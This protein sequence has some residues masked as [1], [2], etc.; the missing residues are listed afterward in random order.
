MFR[1]SLLCILSLTLLL[2]GWAAAA[3]ESGQGKAHLVEINGPI[4]PATADYFTRSL[5]KAEAQG[6]AAQGHA[7]RHA[8]RLL[9]V[10]YT[11]LILMDPASDRAGLK[12]GVMPEIL[13]FV[14][15]FCLVENSST[16]GP[17]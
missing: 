5:D 3:A 7:G 17:K 12:R 14:L 9:A 4:G 8:F 2:V 1:R 10:A 6:A 16:S 13:K 11:S 15:A